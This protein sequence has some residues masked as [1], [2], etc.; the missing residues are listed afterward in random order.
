MRD[1]S[2]RRKKKKKNCCCVLIAKRQ[3]EEEITHSVVVGGGAPPVCV[4]F[5]LALILL[6][7][8]LFGFGSVH[9]SL[10]TPSVN[11]DGGSLFPILLAVLD[12]P[13]SKMDVLAAAKSLAAKSLSG[14]RL[15]F[16]LIL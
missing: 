16:V 4:Q 10:S 3:E 14:R 5:V 13:V 1:S 11:D 12:E 6:A 2:R 15:Q 9:F 8:G 7:C